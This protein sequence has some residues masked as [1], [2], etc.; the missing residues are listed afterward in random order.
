MVAREVGADRVDGLGVVAASYS[1]RFYEE[2]RMV[3]QVSNLDS[4]LVSATVGG[5]SAL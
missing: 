4:W 5:V 1:F 3:D 2:G